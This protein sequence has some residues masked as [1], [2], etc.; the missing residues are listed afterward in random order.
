MGGPAMRRPRVRGEKR[1]TLRIE[2][3]ERRLLLSAGSPD[4]SF[5]TGGEAILP[6]LDT[7]VAAVTSADGSFAV[8]GSEG[9]Q[10]RIARYQADGSPDPTFG[11]SGFITAPIAA[12]G[13][14]DAINAP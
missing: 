8:L 11:T 14:P 9:G 5:G 7:I 12:A 3:L 1:R 4:P 13:G 10:T 6:N 2:P